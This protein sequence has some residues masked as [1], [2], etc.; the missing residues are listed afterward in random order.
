MEQNILLDTGPLVA[1]L[2]KDEHYHQWALEQWQ[3]I[4]P[5][6]ITCESVITESC[7]LMRRVHG[8]RDAVLNLLKQQIVQVPFD[9]DDEIDSIR[10]LLSRYESVPMSLADGC[11]VRMAELY[12]ASKIMTLDSDFRVYRKNRNQIIS[13]IQPDSL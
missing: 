4:E 3:A 10:Q 12:S 9:I 8:G 1:F 2:K 11:L 6:L 13:L 7:F 5:P